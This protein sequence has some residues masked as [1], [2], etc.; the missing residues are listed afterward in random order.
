M[1]HASGTLGAFAC[2]L[3]A[4]GVILAAASAHTSGNDL[5]RT[6]SL[7]LIMHAA[8]VLGISAAAR[9]PAPA[10]AL[11]IA[12]AALGIGSLLFSLDLASRAFLGGRLFAFAAPLGGSL[13]I[14]SWFALAGIFILAALRASR[15]Y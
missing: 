1:T 10:R 2:L 8:A 14:L 11:V 15:D 4:A 6:G 9:A 12:G 5:A 13:M 7:F 3:G